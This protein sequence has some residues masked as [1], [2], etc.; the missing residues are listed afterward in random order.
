VA[1]PPHE[2]DRAVEAIAQEL[3]LQ[4]LGTFIDRMLVPKATPSA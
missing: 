3:G 1:R 4:R 2:R